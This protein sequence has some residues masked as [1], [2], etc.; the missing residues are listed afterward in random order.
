MGRPKTN[1]KK[2]AVTLPGG[3]LASLDRLVVRKFY[4]ESRSEV[5][6]HLLLNALDHLIEIGRLEEIAR[7]K[8]PRGK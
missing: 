5:A 7:R 8:K 6:C 1:S 2:V 4:G 3:A